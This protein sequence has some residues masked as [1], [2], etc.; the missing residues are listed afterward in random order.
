MEEDILPFDGPVACMNDVAHPEQDNHPVS[1][2]TYDLSQLPTNKHIWH[3]YLIRWNAESSS[4]GP[5]KMPCVHFVGPL[6]DGHW[7]VAVNSRIEEQF[8]ERYREDVLDK[9][10]AG[11]HDLRHLFT[12]NDKDIDEHGL[13]VAA[14]KT[15]SDV[16]SRA[17]EGVTAPGCFH[18]YRYYKTVIPDKA[19]LLQVEWARLGYELQKSEPEVVEK[20]MSL[21]L[22]LAPN[23]VEDLNIETLTLQDLKYG[24]KNYLEK[25]ES[26]A[27]TNGVQNANEEGRERSLVRGLLESAYCLTCRHPRKYDLESTINDNR[28]RLGRV[29]HCVLEELLV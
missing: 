9:I 10:E 16:L 12:P 15:R 19:D 1:F 2:N 20:F 11:D 7:V 14:R 17:V 3:G 6:P 5:D 23:F 4:L 27:A 26:L 29:L 25:K 28:E 24:W 13:E 18:L 21:S 22:L 8:K